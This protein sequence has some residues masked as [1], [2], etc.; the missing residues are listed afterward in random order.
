MTQLKILSV[1]K[2]NLINSKIALLLADAKSGSELV[3]TFSV[4]DF[5]EKELSG[6]DLENIF[7]NQSIPRNSLYFVR[8]SFRKHILSFINLQQK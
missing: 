6:H 7:L 8:I 2:W 4:I 1:L 3:T 5:C